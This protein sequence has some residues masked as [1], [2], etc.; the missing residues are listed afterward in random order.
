[1]QKKDYPTP[2]FHMNVSVEHDHIGET[3]CTVKTPEDLTTDKD[4]LCGGGKNTK[5]LMCKSLKITKEMTPIPE[6]DRVK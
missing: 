2:T 4:K 1:M 5:C 3:C 6:V